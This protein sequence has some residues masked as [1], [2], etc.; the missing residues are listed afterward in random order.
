[1]KKTLALT[2]VLALLLCGCGAKATEATTAPAAEPTVVET[3]AATE[4]T[5]EP[6]TVPTEPKVYFNPLNGQILDAPFTGRIFANTV[7]NMQ[8]NLPMWALCRPIC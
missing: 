5:T 7:S 1:M 3:T 6:T 2:L 4:P 8:E